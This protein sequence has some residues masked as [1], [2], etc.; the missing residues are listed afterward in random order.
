MPFL[1]KRRWRSVRGCGRGGPGGP[2]VNE[3]P[4]RAA[5][6]LAAIVLEGDGLLAVLYELLVQDVEH[7]EER[8]LGRHATDLVRDESSRRRRIF[9][10]PDSQCEFH[11]YL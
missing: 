2:S 8:H 3:E 9:L 7:L 5:D 4:P 6:A 11:G 1:R 10:P